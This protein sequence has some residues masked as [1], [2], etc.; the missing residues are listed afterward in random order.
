MN[1]LI[2]NYIRIC[3]RREKHKIFSLITILS[4]EILHIPII[5]PSTSSMF[6]DVMFI[7]YKMIDIY[8]RHA[9]FNYL[10]RQ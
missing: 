10:A 6:F 4:Q 1:L 3:F 5:T 7:V 8:H 2:D 9:M